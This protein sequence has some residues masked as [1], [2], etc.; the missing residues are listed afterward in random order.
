M[1]SAGRC[2]RDSVYRIMRSYAWRSGW[3]R[4]RCR[5]GTAAGQLTDRPSGSAQVCTGHV[6]FGPHHKTDGESLRV[7]HGARVQTVVRVVLGGGVG[8]TIRR[9]GKA[10]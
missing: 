4:T 9:M 5:D 8:H 2:G 10:C 7:A 6:W 1:M 3:L